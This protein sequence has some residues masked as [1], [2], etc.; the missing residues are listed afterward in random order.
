MINVEISIV[1]RNWQ[2]EF[3]FFSDE[4]GGEEGKDGFCLKCVVA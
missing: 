2:N 1:R 4:D 3:V